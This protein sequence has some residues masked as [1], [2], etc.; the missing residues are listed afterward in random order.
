MIL[1]QTDTLIPSQHDWWTDANRKLILCDDQ[2]A[3]QFDIPKN[4]KTVQLVVYDCP[5]QWRLPV[6]LEPNH[7]FASLLPMRVEIEGESHVLDL[8]LG[9]QAQ[10]LYDLGYDEVYVEVLYTD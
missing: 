6:K 8:V 9:K 10:E 3:K 5:S 4:A 1:D 7:G 2:L